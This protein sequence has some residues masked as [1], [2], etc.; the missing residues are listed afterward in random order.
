M[1]GQENEAFTIFKEQVKDAINDLKTKGK[2]HK[3]IPNILTLM[4]LTA[5]CFIIPAAVV[6]N[7]PLIIGLTSIFSLTDLADGFI[8]RNYNLTSELGETLDAVTDKVFA[9]TLLLSASFANPILLLNL[10]MELGIAGINT[11]KKL[12]NEPVKSSLIGKI[13]TWFLFALVGVGFICPY[14]GISDILNSLSFTTSA[15]QALTIASYLA[16]I[17]GINELVNSKIGDSKSSTT[18]DNSEISEQ[19]FLKEKILEDDTSSLK[20]KNNGNESITQLKAMRVFLESE[21][22]FLSSDDSKKTNSANREK[23]KKDDFSSN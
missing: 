8:A 20:D 15:M 12:N 5:P 21:K 7:L 9:S 17:S 10:G 16:P 3:Q 11:R 2:R 1:K 18:I 6:G 23:S 14:F 4:R 19:S 13:K 22:D